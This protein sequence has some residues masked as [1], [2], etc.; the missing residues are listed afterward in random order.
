MDMNQIYNVM[1]EYAQGKSS[2]MLIE[3]CEKSEEHPY[4]IKLAAPISTDEIA[5]V[6]LPGTVSR[7]ENLKACNGILKRLTNFI[8]NNQKLKGIKVRP[9]IAVCDFGDYFDKEHAKK[10]ML[11]EQNNPKKALELIKALPMA[12]R[13]EYLTPNYVKDIYKLVLQDRLVSDKSRI[14]MPQAQALRNIRRTIFVPYCWGGY[15]A[16]KLEHYMQDEMLA[17]HYSKEEREYIQSQ[18]LIVAQS[19]SCPIGISKSRMVS[20]SSASD[21]LTK[22]NNYAKEYLNMNPFGCPD[23][24]SLWLD[25]KD[26]NIFYCTQFNKIGVEGNPKQYRLIKIDDWDDLMKSSENKKKSLGEHD[27]LGFEPTDEMSKAAKKIQHFSNNIII[28]GIKHAANLPK[29]GYRNLP[30]T[31]RLAANTPK[32]HWDL[33]QAYRMGLALKLNIKDYGKDNIMKNSYAAN[34]QYVSLD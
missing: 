4:G 24:G 19:P 22:H 1:I 30:N 8:E 16:L 34:V 15:T 21:L 31:R 33:F 23:F 32:D 5:V 14:R 3:R 29:Q 13:Q 9:V 2:A 26:G 12:E 11:L 7:K 25:S 27:F 10:L 28:N 20:F 18:M 17:L 6:A